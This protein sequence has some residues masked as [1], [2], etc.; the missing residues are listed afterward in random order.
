M[1]WKLQRKWLEGAWDGII[2]ERH[3]KWLD[4]HFC[5]RARGS[6]WGGGKV[7]EGPQ[8]GGGRTHRALLR[9]LV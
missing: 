8:K 2:S 4:T 1:G 5:G 3:E 7:A 6:F 9:V